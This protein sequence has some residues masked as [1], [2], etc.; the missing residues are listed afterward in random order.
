MTDGVVLNY[1]FPTSA[2]EGTG[3]TAK[4][5]DID[6]EKDWDYVEFEFTISDTVLGDKS[7]LTPP[8]VGDSDGKFKV[9]IRQYGTTVD[10]GYGF[11]SYKEWGSAGD[12]AGKT[13]KIQTW[14]AGGKG[15]V[16]IA[17]NY[18]DKDDDGAVSM[19]IKLTKVTFT[20]GQ[21]H[22]V[23]F[24][25]PYTGFSKS[26]MVL[27]GNGLNADM[28]TKADISLFGYT[29]VGWTSDYD[30]IF[31]GYASGVAPGTAITKPTVL[32][33][34]WFFGE[35]P[36]VTKTGTD[37]Y[38][39]IKQGNN[40]GKDNTAETI[41]T[42]VGGL[43]WITLS[44]IDS[45]APAYNWL[46]LTLEVESATADDTSKPVQTNLKGAPNAWSPNYPSGNI[47][48]SSDQ[49]T[50]IKAGTVVL[51]LPISEMNGGFSCQ[52]N[53]GSFKFVVTSIELKASL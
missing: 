48:G 41:N 16:T 53:N 14:G 10:Y 34:A 31:T 2:V 49:F 27:D 19:K 25:D 15:G 24:Q 9:I 21:R 46:V 7:K 1:K 44:E 22:P 12:G 5:V 3:T 6:I 8:K 51:K 4:T 36:T 23:S 52:N 32:Y 17:Y 37:A 43:W 30:E 45:Y 20:K 33:A 11:G 18:Y 13:Q 28:P 29:F 39:L 50:D 42:S 26:V 47:E 38:S 40:G 35:L